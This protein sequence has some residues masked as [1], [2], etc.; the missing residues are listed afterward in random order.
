MWLN[1]L[2]KVVPGYIIMI[3]PFENCVVAV[4]HDKIDEVLQL[5]PKLVG[6]DEKVMKDVEN[7]VSVKE[8]FKRHRDV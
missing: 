7:G 3:D 4:K 5:L 8:A 6:A 2:V 1:E